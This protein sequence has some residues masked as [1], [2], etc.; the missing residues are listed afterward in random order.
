VHRP[1]LQASCTL[2][3]LLT[4]VLA[5]AQG[6]PVA[7]A[8][9]AAPAP[10][11]APAPAAAAPTPAPAATP[12]D[13]S[14]AP[15]APRAWSLDLTVDDVGIGIGNSRR[16]DGLRL[17]VTD[18]APFVVNGVNLTLWTPQEHGG[19]R[20]NGLALGVPLTGVRDLAGV[21]VGIGLGAEDSMAGLAVGVIGLGAGKDV[22]G[23][24]LA[25]IGAGAGRNVSGVIIA[26]LG[27]GAGGS[28]YGLSVGGL[29]F[30]AGEDVVGLT[31][32]GLGAGAGGSVRG[33][34]IAGLGVGAGHDLDGISL[35]LGGLG[36][37]QHVRGLMIAGLGMGSGGSLAGVGV[38]GLGLGAPELDGLDIALAVGAKDARGVF[39]APAWFEIVDGG[40]VE[41]LSIS[42]VNRIRGEQRGL[43]IGVVNYAHSLHGVQIGLLNWA[44]NSSL[45]KL[46]P[47]V[48]VHID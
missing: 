45:L 47:L 28:V 41:G 8:A 20:V 7:S 31:V 9:A 10:T 22:S 23:V 15:D 18:A 1:L 25:G 43:A 37:G 4:S 30:G 14:R 2:A 19:G 39:L 17:N 29:G 11:A 34:N 26:G 16:V 21:G 32:A 48:N 24:A 13:P 36:A 12:A 46:M 6:A 5:G 33:V 3:V 35:A 38:A 27:G 42:A 44:D 40:S